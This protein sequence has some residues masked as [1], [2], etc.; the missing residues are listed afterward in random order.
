MRAAEVFDEEIV[1]SLMTNAWIAVGDV[2]AEDERRFEMRIYIA[3]DAAPSDASMTVNRRMIS[4]QQ[5]L[6]MQIRLK[7]AEGP[8]HIDDLTG[9]VGPR[10]VDDGFFFDVLINVICDLEEP[11]GRRLE[12][13]S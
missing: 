10:G 4:Q 8:G 2:S 12:I 13:A 9:P 1:D 7:P 6:V 11:S 3:L 5:Q